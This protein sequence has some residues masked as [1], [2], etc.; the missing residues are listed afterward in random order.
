MNTNKV[1]VVVAHPDDEVI[2]MGGTISKHT[3]EGDEVHVVCVTG[4][5][6]SS[7]YNRHT[8]TSNVAP[9]LGIYSYIFLNFPD[10]QLDTIT[11][12]SINN[13]ISQKIQTIKPNIVYTHAREDL[14][15]DHRIVHDSVMVTC[16]PTGSCS[17]KELYTFN[18]SQWD[19]GEMGSFQPNTFVD[20]SRYLEKK[21][22]AMNCYP[23]ELREPPHPMSIE[24]IR[25]DSINKGTKFCLS[26]VEEFKQ[27][28]RII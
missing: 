16:R 28:F 15:I 18:V 1:L 24:C 4:G 22:E 12:S 11:Q 9:I 8:D 25:R 6:T 27:V 19:F 23:S 21:M 26:S 17:V 7:G 13:I 2:G 14:N 3:N 5:E 10:Q 20:I